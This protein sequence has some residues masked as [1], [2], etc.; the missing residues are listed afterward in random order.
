MGVIYL[1]G[2]AYGGGSGG[3][4]GGSKDYNEL[5][6]KPTINNVVLF[7]NRTTTDLDLVDG[8]TIFVNSNEKMGVGV[9]SNS[10]INA[11]FN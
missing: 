5:V 7:G 6:N 9:I 1:N 8:D 2:I 4:G 3:G 11:L 10:Q